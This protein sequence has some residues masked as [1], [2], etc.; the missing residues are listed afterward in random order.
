MTIVYCDWTSGNDSTGDGTYGNPYKTITTAS[1]GLSGG[2]EVRVAKS[3]AHTALSQTLSWTDNSTSVGTTGDLTGEL[4]AG[5]MVGKNDDDGMWWEITGINSTT[6]TLRA[7]YSGTTETVTSYKMGFHDYGSPAATSTQVQAVSD[8][9]SSASSLLTISGGWN[10]TTQEQDGWSFFCVTHATNRYGYGLYYA[11]KD[12][13]NLS[14]IVCARCYSGFYGTGVDNAVFE[15]VEAYSCTQYGFYAGSRGC[16]FT[17]IKAAGCGYCNFYLNDDGNFI[18]DL[19]CA[20]GAG[21]S[22]Y[23]GV[24]LAAEQIVATQIST[25]NNTNYGFYTENGNIVG[26][27]VAD[28]NSRG[29]NFSSTIGGFPIRIGKL[30]ASGN[31]TALYAHYPCLCR[32]GTFI[33]SGNTADFG[34]T[35]N[36]LSDCPHPVFHIQRWNDT[37]GDS[38]MMFYNGV[39]YRDTADARSGACLKAAPTSADDYI[40]VTLG[41]YLVTAT[42]SDITLTIYAKDDASFNG[43]VGLM[44]LINNG[45]AVAWTEKTMATSYGAHTLT[46]PAASLVENEWIEL[47][48][49]VRGTAGAVYFDDFS[50]A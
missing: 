5:D 41:K 29:I 11:N 47:I 1:N 50:A 15:D 16:S 35:S 20:S 49:R 14:K 21:S 24:S 7:K 37:A 23:P 18:D 38:R 26:E 36:Y 48:A 42:G 9:G 33:P 45:V 4:A 30:S 12:Y 39:A 40:W 28:N 2:D 34:Y 22:T 25:R 10:L 46:V 3:P 13:I 8:S 43:D 31:T 17:R 6:I 27:L 19:K 44:A 32:V